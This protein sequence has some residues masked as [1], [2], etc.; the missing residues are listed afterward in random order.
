ML[1]APH[2]GEETWQM[3]EDRVRRLEEQA[4][5]MGDRLSEGVEQVQEKVEQTVK[6]G[7]EK[8]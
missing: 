1:Q 6:E 5:E 7:S 2:S 8:A 3:I 4:D